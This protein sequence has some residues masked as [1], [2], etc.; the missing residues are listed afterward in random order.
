MATSSKP[1]K[2]PAATAWTVCFNLHLI[3]LFLAG[4]VR[5]FRQ[6]KKA[7]TPAFRGKFAGFRDDP[8]QINAKTVGHPQCSLQGRPAQAALDVANHLLGNAASLLHS[9]FG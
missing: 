1:I 3:E 8:S 6:I 2:L 4:E 5:A 7:S 9:V